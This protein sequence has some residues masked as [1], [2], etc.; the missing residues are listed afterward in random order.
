MISRSLQSRVY[1][2]TDYSSSPHTAVTQAC[3]QV[4]LCAVCKKEAGERQKFTSAGQP[5]AF[6]C[7]AIFPALRTL[8]WRDILLMKPVTITAPK[9]KLAIESLSHN[10][11]FQGF[12]CFT[13]I[14]IKCNIR[15]LRILIPYYR[16]CDVCPNIKT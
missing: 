16:N 2:H 7:P 8:L 15:C 13:S 12:P 10:S 3:K 4:S 1:L 9:V 14:L 5:S 6:S 11:K